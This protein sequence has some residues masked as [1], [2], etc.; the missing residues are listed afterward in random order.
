MPRGEA[1]REKLLHSAV[2]LFHE[3][4]YNGTSVQ[5]IVSEARVPKGSFY[6]YFKSKEDI[7]IAASD[8]FYSLLLSHLDLENASSPVRRLRKFFRLILREMKRYEYSRGC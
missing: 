4:G 5:D 8:V 2:R 3:F 7:A 6:N 1:T